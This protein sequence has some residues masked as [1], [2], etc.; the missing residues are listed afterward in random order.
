MIKYLRY[1]IAMFRLNMTVVC[2]ESNDEH[3]FH[4]YEDSKIGVP[5]H[6]YTYVCKRCKKTFQI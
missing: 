4:D 1:F 3:D 5:M 2:E 6:G